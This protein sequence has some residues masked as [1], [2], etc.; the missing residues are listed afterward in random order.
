LNASNLTILKL[1]D[2]S[3]TFVVRS[4]QMLI[5]IIS[6]FNNLWT[7]HSTDTIQTRATVA[8][9]INWDNTL[10]I[11]LNTDIWFLKY[12]SCRLYFSNN[13]IDLFPYI[14]IRLYTLRAIYENLYR[15]D[16]RNRIVCFSFCNDLVVSPKRTINLFVLNVSK[17]IIINA[18]R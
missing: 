11:A 13:S 6:L 10:C 9:E 14:I 4:Y 2:R 18:G 8:V 3:D 7:P 17:C 16:G 1:S 15:E 5:H 12:P